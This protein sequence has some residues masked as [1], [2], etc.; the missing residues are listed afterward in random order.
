MKALDRLLR[1]RSVAVIGASADPGKLTARPVS[2]LLRHGYPGRILPVNPRGGEIAGLRCHPDIASLPEAPDAAIVLL[3]HDRAEEAVRALAARGT[4]AAIVLAG[5]YAEAGEEGIRRQRALVEAAGAMRLLGP[6]TIG[7][8]NLT[9]RITLSASGALAMAELPAGAVSIVS[10]SGGVLG[11]LLSRAADRG[12]GLARLVSTGNEADLDSTDLVEH[13][14]DDEAT[15]VIALYMEGLRRPEAFRAAALRAAAA[16][17]PV[18]VFKIGRSESGARSATSHTGA[19][20]GVD[21]VY[22][23]FFRQCGIIRAETFADLLDI[24]AALVPGRRARG[25]RVAI[26]TSSGG[27]GALVADSLGLAGFDL[28]PPDPATAARLAALRGEDPAEMRNPVDLTLAGLRP[29][30]L[31]GALDALLDSPSYDATVVVVGSSAVAQPGLVADAVLERAAGGERPLICYISPHAPEVTR[32]LNGGGVPSFAAPESCAAVLAALQARP[33]PALPAAAPGPPG[34][35][36]ASMGAGRL[37]EAQSEVLFEAFGIPV[38]REAVA[39]DPAGTLDAAEGLGARVVLKALSRDIPHKSDVGGVR[40]GL[41]AEELPA[42]AAAMLE[43]LARAGAPPPEGFLVQEMVR[44]GIEMILGFHRD[45]QLG[46]VFLLGMGGVTAELI[47]DTVLRLPPLTREDA[48]GMI[49]GLRTAA[50]LSG[51]RGVPPSDRAALADA[52]LAFAALA[53]AAGERLLEAEIN[54]L[55]VLPEGQGVRALDG[56]VVLAG[57]P[58]APA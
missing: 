16:G 6:N 42:A 1:P 18:V 41:P 39:P 27:A 53:A 22:D 25:R 43:S 46:P 19:L 14:I 34:P 37:N 47:Q 40:V 33:V 17:K 50:L 12:V 54:P 49:A 10:Q 31:R 56:L 4:A 8:V 44:G 7:L 15:R 9:D 5:G 38:T 21:R 58:P 32:R 28:A 35:L 23:A 57:P 2:Y 55:V 48:E 36:L 51:Y 45:P 11:S 3:E 20:A 26:L 30:L 29:D 24:P 13:L 52:I